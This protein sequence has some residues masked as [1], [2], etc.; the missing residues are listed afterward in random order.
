M[1]FLLYV[2]PHFASHQCAV[3]RS[4]NLS[5]KF[6]L[7]SLGIFQLEAF[8]IFLLEVPILNVLTT[9]AQDCKSV[10]KAIN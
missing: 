4:E 3:V 2:M 9:E 1:I 7:P 6:D 8:C 10:V 5:T